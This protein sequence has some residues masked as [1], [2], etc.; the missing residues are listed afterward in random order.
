MYKPVS[1]ADFAAITD[2]MARYCHHIDE[3]EAEAWADCYT[4]DG[5]FDGPATPAPL[6]GR[7]ALAGFARATYGAAQGMMRHQVANLTCDYGAA[8]DAAVA[9]LYNLVTTW[10]GGGR[11]SLMAVCRLDLVRADGRWRIQRNA[12]RLLGA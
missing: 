10:Q 6:V 9:R 7:E 2:L 3:G 4:P 5:A 8:E 11:V 1:V 12:Y